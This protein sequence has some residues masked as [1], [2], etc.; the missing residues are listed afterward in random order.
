MNPRCEEIQSRLDEWLD[1]ELN[2]VSRAEVT[3]HL[4]ECAEC[5]DVFTSFD[6]LNRNLVGLS[7]AADRIATAPR[8][9]RIIR[10][11]ATPLRIAAAIALLATAGLG[12]RSALHRP[13]SPSQIVPPPVVVA[14]NSAAPTIVAS[15]PTLAVSLP[16]RNPHISIVMLYEPV[17][18]PSA[19][20]A[21]S[22]PSL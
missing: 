7:S 8:P 4:T 10:P 6:L 1:N 16:T 18:L 15:T 21:E 22:K 13:D 17:R 14:E 9:P 3:T 12:V 5:R 19:S 11:F 20:P 2:P